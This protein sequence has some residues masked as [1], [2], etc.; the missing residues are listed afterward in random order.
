MRTQ[1]AIIGA[2]PAGLTLALLLAERGIEAVV[3]ERASREHVEER[4]RAG[5]LEQN[6]VELLGALGAGERLAREALVHEGVNIRHEGRDLRIPLAELTGRPLTIYGQQQVVR[7]LVAAWLARGGTLRFEAAG[8]ALHALD[9]DAPRVTWTEAGAPHALD[10]DV[11]AGCD[12]FHGAS[13]A[14]I[15]S[16]VLVEYETTYPFAWL[17][18]LAEAP[19]AV[20]EVVYGWHERGFALHSMRSPEIS[21]L[22]LQV[23]SDTRLED[24]TDEEI[25][26]ELQIR[27]A[28]P[29][30]PVNVGPVIE[31]SL[32]PLR[33]YVCEPLRHGRLFLTGDAAHIVP[34]TGA[35]GLNLAVNDARLLAAALDAFYARGDTSGLDGY[36]A[37]ALRRVWR[38]QDFST[39]L[40]E[41]LHDLG[42]GPYER[43][44][45]VARLDYLGRSEAA[46]RSFA[47]NYVGV[48]AAPDFWA[49]LRRGVATP[50]G[51]L[52]RRLLR[53]GRVGL[54]VLARA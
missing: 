49:R 14:A 34:P 44:L 3:L 25:W 29:E 1:V 48:P 19:P 31:R 5:V 22:Y 46:Q 32:S 8:V 9:T 27:L 54:A 21:R 15:P 39:Y 16:G 26:A 50:A 12:G 45:Q 13:R 37:T 36:S 18:I 38:A 30:H 6:T 2:G 24:W 52:S 17:G 53:R 28:G 43:R 23:P 51:P 10:C 4:V 35:K 7:D 33:S 47:E 41:L 11:V 20:E 42:G 40:T